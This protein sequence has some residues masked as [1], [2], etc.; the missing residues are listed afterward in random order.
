MGKNLQE[1]INPKIIEGVKQRLKKAR[2]NKKLTQ[3]EV[4]KETG[5][6]VGRLESEGYS[7]NMSVITLIILCDLYEIR[8]SGL[9]KGL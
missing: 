6:H 9:F 3:A 1:K 8:I 4:L 5:I 2:R 7:K